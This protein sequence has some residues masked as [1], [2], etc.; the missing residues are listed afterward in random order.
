MALATQPSHCTGDPLRRIRYPGSPNRTGHRLP[1]TAKRRESCQLRGA[2][3]DQ[4]EDVVL[5]Y[6]ASLRRRRAR[7][8]RPVQAMI[9]PGN[10]APTIGPGTAEILIV[11]LL[12]AAPVAVTL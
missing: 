9:K 5:T 11:A 10:P 2:C 12:S 1:Q 6:M 8:R 4:G 7:T 3:N